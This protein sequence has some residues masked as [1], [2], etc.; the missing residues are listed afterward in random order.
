MPAAPPSCAGSAPCSSRSRARAAATPASQPAALS[1]NVTG[2]RLLHQRAARHQRAAVL[3]RQPRAGL[4][5]R[6]EL[7][8]HRLERALRD[9]HRRAVEHV[10]ARRAEVHA[11][12]LVVADRLAQRRDQRHDRVG[13]ARAATPSSSTS[14]VAARSPRPPRPGS[15]PRPPRRAASAASTSSIAR[16][17]ASSATASCTASGT[18]IGVNRP[19]DVKKCGLALALEVDVEPEVVRDQRVAHGWIL[20]RRQQRVGCVR[21]STPQFDDSGSRMLVTAPDQTVQVYDMA[22]RTRIGEAIPAAADSGMVEGWLRP[23]G[24][25]VAVNGP[26][27]VL[28]WTLEPEALAAAACEIAGRNLTRAEWS[29]YLGD[30]EVPADLPGFPSGDEDPRGR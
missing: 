7:G 20:D 14:G 29:T 23:D 17:H 2:T 4:D 21:P 22:S 27:G 30:A 16:S 1:P 12:R 24:A 3:A 28:E 11:A 19:L 9:Q 5:D 6:V 15:R 13:G 25:A 26:F 10:L 8:Q 18:K